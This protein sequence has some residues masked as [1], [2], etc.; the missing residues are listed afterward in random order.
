MMDKTTIWIS[1][2]L[3]EKLDKLGQKGD[4]YEDIIGKLIKN[5]KKR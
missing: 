1:K 2:E 4:T 3:K 5:D